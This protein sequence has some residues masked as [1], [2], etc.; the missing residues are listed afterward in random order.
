MQNYSTT[1]VG[2]ATIVVGYILINMGFSQA[3]GNEIMQIGGVAVTA[4][5]AW[6]KRYKAGGVTVFGKRTGA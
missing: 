5:Y 2:L 3:C 1:G 4:L 6:Y